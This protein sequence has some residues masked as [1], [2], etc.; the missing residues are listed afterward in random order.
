MVCFHPALWDGS[1]HDYDLPMITMATEVATD[2]NPVVLE[3]IY[4]SLLWLFWNYRY[5]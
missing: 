5:V 1:Q 3:M 2:L 4:R